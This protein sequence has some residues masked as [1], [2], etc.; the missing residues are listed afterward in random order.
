[1]ATLFFKSFVLKHLSCSNKEIKPKALTLHILPEIVAMCFL[2]TLT[3]TNGSSLHC[4]FCGVRGQGF[5]QEKSCVR[6][7][8]FLA[9]PILARVVPS[10]AHCNCGLVCAVAAEGVAHN[11]LC[12]PMVITPGTGNCIF[13]FSYCFFYFFSCFLAFEGNELRNKQLT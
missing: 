3:Y 5:H 4:F 8:F 9:N 12:L 7:C 13:H 2:N 11:Q 10:L 1:M 6:P